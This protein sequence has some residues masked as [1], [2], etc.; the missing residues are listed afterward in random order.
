MLSTQYIG[1]SPQWIAHLSLNFCINLWNQ[2]SSLARLTQFKNNWLVP[3]CLME[4][5]KIRLAICKTLNG[6]VFHAK[7]SFRE[8]T[9]R[10]MSSLVCTS[11]KQYNALSPSQGNSWL[12]SFPPKIPLSS[13]P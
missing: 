1:D 11:V 3:P 6:N 13:N 12:K 5:A 8:N 4:P 7:T 10:S 2:N 9:S